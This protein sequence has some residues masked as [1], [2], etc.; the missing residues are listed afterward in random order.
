[1]LKHIIDEGS[2]H[3]VHSEMNGILKALFAS[4]NKNAVKLCTKCGSI[5]VGNKML[6]HQVVSNHNYECTRMILLTSTTEGQ[7]DRMCKYYLNYKN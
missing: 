2:E 7:K 6:K 1:M 5:Y 3:L 4:E